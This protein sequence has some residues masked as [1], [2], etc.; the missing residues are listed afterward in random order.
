MERMLLTSLSEANQLLMK[1]RLL[2]IEGVGGDQAFE[3]KQVLFYKML[4]R[5]KSEK[6]VVL[7]SPQV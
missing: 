5:F 1:L 2:R 6:E 3:S 4:A 7:T